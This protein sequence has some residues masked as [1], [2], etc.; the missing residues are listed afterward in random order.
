MSSDQ[1]GKIIRCTS[2]GDVTTNTEDAVLTEIGG[3][4]ESGTIQAAVASHINWYFSSGDGDEILFK[5]GVKAMK[6][7]GVNVVKEKYPFAFGRVSDHLV[8]WWAKKTRGNGQYTHQC[9]LQVSGLRISV[10]IENRDQIWDELKRLI[11]A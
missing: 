4:K 6:N 7:C 3:E 5:Q 1:A 2:D 8:T 10:C 11:G 9:V